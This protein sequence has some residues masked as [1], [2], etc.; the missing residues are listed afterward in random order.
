MLRH[1]RVEGVGRQAV[2]ALEKTK[3]ARGNNDM[4]ILA[5]EA[6]RA[7]TVF[8]LDPI[9]QSNLKPHRAAMTAACMPF[10]FIT[11]KTPVDFG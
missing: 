11:H 9:G 2:F 4:R 6:D 3:S 8:N 7:I 10:Q 1:S 5:F